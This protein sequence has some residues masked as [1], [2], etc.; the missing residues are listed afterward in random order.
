MN[1]TDFKKVDFHMV[2]CNTNKNPG[3]KYPIPDKLHKACYL[4]EMAFWLY[5]KS[6]QPKQKHSC[7]TVIPATN[8]TITVDVN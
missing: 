6:I 3:Y 5:N 1:Q 4:D 8:V 7:N 2:I